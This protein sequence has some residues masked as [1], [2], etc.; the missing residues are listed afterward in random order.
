MM[1]RLERYS[2]NATH[3]DEC[4]ET[5]TKTYDASA[6]TEATGVAISAP[7]T[8]VISHGDDTMVPDAPAPSHRMDVD[9][10]GV[11]TL[12]SS[13]ITG[14]AEAGA[15]DDEALIALRREVYSLTADMSVE[16]L[17]AISDPAVRAA[18]LLMADLL[19][20]RDGDAAGLTKLAV[21]VE[22]PEAGRHGEMALLLF[23]EALAIR[24]EAK[25]KAFEKK[26]PG[27]I[28]AL[29]D[30]GREALLDEVARLRG[31]R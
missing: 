1:D 20:L 3:D 28:K 15:Q 5:E 11:A 31:L 13:T 21:G 23:R 4:A 9:S 14:N 17:M 30:F 10:D 16:Q 6:P 29:S 18:G 8:A 27:R 19:A 12:A 22:I 26:R 7:L 25:R 24:S 2:R